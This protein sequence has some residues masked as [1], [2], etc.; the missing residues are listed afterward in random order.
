MV[1]HDMTPNQLPCFDMGALFRILDVHELEL[2]LLAG[3][4][5]KEGFFGSDFERP[6][7]RMQDLRE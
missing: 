5:S 6:Q 7:K 1:L 4:H 3:S 2:G